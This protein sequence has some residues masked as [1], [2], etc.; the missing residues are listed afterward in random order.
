MV[1][2]IADIILRVSGST[3]AAGG[4]VAIGLGGEVVTVDPF[5]SA[6]RIWTIACGGDH[7]CVSSHFDEICSKAL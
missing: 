3:E 2:L 7:S 4:I 5:D 6:I 1:L